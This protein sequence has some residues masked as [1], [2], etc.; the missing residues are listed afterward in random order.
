MARIRT[1]RK[2]IHPHTIVGQQGVN[3]IEEA[4][5]A[6]GYVWSPMGIEA[7]IDGTIEIRNAATGEM[8]HSIIRV[9]SKATASSFTGDDGKCFAYVCDERD[10]DYWMRGN[11][12]VILVRSRTDTREAYWVSIKDY[13][14]DPERRKTRKVVFDKSRDVL[15]VSA[16]GALRRL[17]VPVDSG[18]YLAP[19]RKNE[20]VYSNLLPVVTAPPRLFHALTEYGSRDAFREALREFTKYPHREWVTQ[21]KTVISVHDLSQHPW[22]RV[23]DPGTVEE[24]ETADWSDSDDEQKRRDF[25]EL[26]NYCLVERLAPDRV[27]FHEKKKIFYF[28]ATKN[29]SPR[30]ISY[31]NVKQA[32]KKE[33]F[34]PYYIK[35]DPSRVAYYRHSAF[36]G[37]FV[38]HEGVWFLEVEP[39]YHF[40]RDGRLGD[41]YGASRLSGIKRLEHNPAV[42]GQ[43]MM[44][45]SVLTKTATLFNK[46]YPYLIFGDFKTFDLEH[47]IADDDWLKHEEPEEAPDDETT[48]SLFQ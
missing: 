38:R 22:N 48:A 40:T 14:K 17:A 10:L 47:G 18:I 34:G 30:S 23:V 35:K 19:S 31:Q 27:R 26:L 45:R 2:Q 8:L 3:I 25:A 42:L 33:V 5:L 9:Q 24:F 37:H 43:L 46:A 21:G 29:L 6:M 4:V 7:G 44:W 36:T 15:N 16:A 41:R 12:P 32:A 11:A 39:T 20:T 13:F 28:D 1:S